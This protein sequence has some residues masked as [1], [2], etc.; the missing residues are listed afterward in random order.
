M[1]NDRLFR[2]DFRNAFLATVENNKNPVKSVRVINC[3][4]IP[5]DGAVVRTPTTVAYVDFI[6]LRSNS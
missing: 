5:L 2:S 4:D 1:K 3:L 6:S